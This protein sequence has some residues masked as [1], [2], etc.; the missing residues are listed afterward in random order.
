LV[1]GT[2]GL[3]ASIGAIVSLTLG[4]IAAS[5]GDFLSAMICFSLAGALAGFLR[6]N[7]SRAS[8]YLGD[9]GSMLIGLVTAAV[10]IECSIKQQTAFALAVPAA[11][12][13]IPALDAAAALVRRIITG[14]SVFTADRG[15]LHHAL[16]LRGWSNGQTVA[17]IAGLTSLTCA[18]A[19][20]S[21]FTHSD[22]I[23]VPITIAVFG[24]LAATRVFGHAEAA[25]IFNRLRSL[26]RSTIM[27]PIQ[28]TSLES[29]ST[30]RLQGNR[31]WQDLWSSLREA[32]PKYNVAGMTLQV[33]IPG[34]HESFFATWK[35]NDA[36]LGDD[37]WRVALPL[38]F[39]ERRIGK[40]TMLGA[41]GG[42]QAVSELQQLF[43]YLEM[44]DGQIMQIIDEVAI[45]SSGAN[46]HATM[47]SLRLAVAAGVSSATDA[48]AD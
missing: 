43:D 22:L 39:G 10:A 40:L 17:F 37:S 30:V 5:R 42:S 18:A 1:D 38:E 44:L 29:E 6:F 21:Y 31:K 36:K 4:I 35:Q 47:P 45:P 24:T 28:R 26:V 15:H 2:D 20:A 48:D 19:L 8:V 14:Q 12:C 13:A 41:S 3:A 33:S 16:L 32:A 27:G 11:I 9:T 23:A 7:L 25:L 46:G 34:Y